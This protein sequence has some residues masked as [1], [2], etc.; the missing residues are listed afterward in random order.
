MKQIECCVMT[1]TVGYYANLHSMNP[2][3]RAEV[4][5]RKLYDTK[6]IPELLEKSLTFRSL[7]V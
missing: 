2:G 6:K 1:R 5:N 3:K 4:K 7:N